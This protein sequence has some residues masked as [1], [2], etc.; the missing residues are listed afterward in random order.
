MAYQPIFTGRHHQSEPSRTLSEDDFTVP[1]EDRYF[2]DYETGS[3]YEYGYYEVD[4]AEVIDFA[5][6]FD[7]QTFHTDPE[8]AA[9]TQFGGLIASGWHVGA[10][11]MRLFGDHYL[12]KAASLASPGVDEMRW[13]SPVRPGDRLKLRTTTLEARLSRSKPDRGLVR[14]KAELINQDDAVPTTLIA[15]NFIA[16]RPL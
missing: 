13:S 16:C 2:E 3:V 12:T 8:A 1:V 11:F 4:E 10:I 7:P 9:R 6:R 5:K 15:V 14:T